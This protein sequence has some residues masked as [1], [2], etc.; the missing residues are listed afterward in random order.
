MRFSLR[1][2]V[3]C[4]H[5]DGAT[6]RIWEMEASRY[7]EESFLIPSSIKLPQGFWLELD[8]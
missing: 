8:A 3:T 4:H 2:A 6:G 1:Q 5:L 7:L